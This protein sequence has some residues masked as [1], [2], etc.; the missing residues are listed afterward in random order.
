MGPAV[1]GLV[2]DVNRITVQNDFLS[3][4][5]GNEEKSSYM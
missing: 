4:I 2:D 3:R 1:E 5:P